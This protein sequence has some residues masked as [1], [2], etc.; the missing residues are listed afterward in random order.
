MTKRIN[1]IN[2][3]VDE[4]EEQRGLN[5]DFGLESLME[6]VQEQ[7]GPLGALRNLAEDLRPNSRYDRED[8]EI[9]RPTI[10]ITELWGK[11]DNGDR[12]IIENFSRGIEGDTMEA[13]IIFLNSILTGEKESASLSEI[14]STLV[15][16]E[17]LYSILSEFTESA[18]GFLF[19]GFLA[20]LFGGQSVQIVSPS[21][22]PGAG[23]QAGKPITDILVLGDKHY[24]LKLLGPETGVGGSFRNMVEHFEGFPH[25][26]YLDAR[27]IG[28]VEG[29]EFLE[30][31]ITLDSFLEAFW[32]PFRGFKKKVAQ[33]G[34]TKKLKNAIAKFGD[35]IFKVVITHKVK[36]IT[37]NR[38]TYMPEEILNFDEE[39]LEMMSPFAVHY[40]EESFAKSPKAKKLFG[41]GRQLNDVAEAIELRDKKKIMEALRQTA[42]FINSEQFE[43][44]RGQAESISS[45][46]HVGTIMIGEEHM[47]NLWWRHVDLLEETIGPV[48]ST[49]QSF[50]DNINNYFL[51]LKKAEI[52]QPRKQFAMDAIKD[53]KDLQNA[54]NRA[55]KRVEATEK[56]VAPGKKLGYKYGQKIRREE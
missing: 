42:G 37:G 6:L 39:V 35:K 4:Y 19:E 45:A 43:L 21:D 30:F 15:I 46:K 16:C 5:K 33:V 52:K 34:T 26:Y 27:R 14:L 9:H 8:I 50:T 3:L 47:K 18:G 17:V 24:S 38:T 1:E 23:A 2:S 32:E 48:Y 41:T 29:L 54:S 20:G 7:L 10:K 11:L 28:K 44:T 55:M 36:G 56:D 22:I 31:K 40:S 51:G 49:L 12:S 53:A 25:V 13:K